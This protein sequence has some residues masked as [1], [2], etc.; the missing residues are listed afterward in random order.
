MVCTNAAGQRVVVNAAPSSASLTFHFA[1]RSPLASVQS[2]IGEIRHNNTAVV[3]LTPTSGT[4]AIPLSQAGALLSG[5]DKL[6]VQVGGHV[7]HGKIT[8]IA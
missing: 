6:Y 5:Q 2:A 7:Y 3:T 8:R 4:V 1:A